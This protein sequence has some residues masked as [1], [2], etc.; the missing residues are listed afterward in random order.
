MS[1]AG[2]TNWGDSNDLLSVPYQYGWV[3][4]RHV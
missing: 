2:V 3:V 4:W 1:V